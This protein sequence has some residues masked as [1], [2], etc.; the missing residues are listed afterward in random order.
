[1]T[2]AVTI[3]GATVDA[4]D[5]LAVDNGNGVRVPEP[6]TLAIFGLGLAGLGLMR[7]RKAG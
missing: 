1:M 7:R 4:L 2:G 6:A 5:A 3:I